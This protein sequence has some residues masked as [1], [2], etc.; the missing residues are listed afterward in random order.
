MARV[1]N[2][3]DQNKKLVTMT[4][5]K[6][7]TAPTKTTYTAGETFD[8][9][10]MVIEA[11]YSNGSHE[12]VSGYTY[13]PSGVL[14]V[15]ITEIVVTYV[16]D[17]GEFQV[18]VPITVNKKK[19]AV[20]YQTGSL[21]Y[22]GNTQHPSWANYDSNLMTIS[23]TTGAMNAGSYTASFSLND[24]AN[25]EW[26]DGTTG[27]KNVTWSISKVSGYLY[28]SSYNVTVTDSS[29]TV[30]IN[31]S[32]GGSYSTST[33][34]NSVATA[35]TSG[36]TI[37]I[38]A[39]SNGLCTITVRS[40]ATTNYT[41]ASRDIS[42]Q[43]LLSEHVLVD[44]LTAIGSGNY[45]FPQDGQ[46]IAIVIGGG[47]CGG[48]PNGY[49]GGKG[50]R[51]GNVVLTSYT[52]VL[53]GT[54]AGYVVGYADRNSGYGYSGGNSSFLGYTAY[55]GA[56]AVGADGGTGL[57]ANGTGGGSTYVTLDGKEY[58]AGSGGGG[59]YGQSSANGTR[60]YGGTGG[61]G[62]G[63]A[64]G[65]G[66][67]YGEQ[68]TNGKNATGYGG[69]GGGAGGGKIAAGLGYGGEGYRGA[70]LIFRKRQ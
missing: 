12:T 29:L 37:T 54:T 49:E 53:A 64:G 18:T 13:Q 20:P 62:G 38:N 32:H 52:T 28:L 11:Y 30:S 35:S 1:L 5:I 61:T 46:Y 47:G 16:G 70:I 55:G 39:V 63:G 14:N 50:G 27:Q 43:V 68:A 58:R 8:P 22:S 4:E 3:V 40:A 25:H 60:G 33:S 7:T 57:S 2:M 44:T 42:V 19:I 59:G 24:T 69:G 56:S 21:S 31:S 67:I 26:A 6:V 66:A 15:T 51:S 23:G 45:T 34:N 17:N 48:R 41:S 10:G 65:D 9:S 36:S